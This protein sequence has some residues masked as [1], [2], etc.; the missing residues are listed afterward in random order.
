[1]VQVKLLYRNLLLTDGYD[2]YI[3]YLCTWQFSTFTNYTWYIHKC[4]IFFALHTALSILALTFDKCNLSMFSP[5]ICIHSLWVPQPIHNI[6][7]AKWIFYD[8]CVF[9]YITHT[10]DFI[11][12]FLVFFFFWYFFIFHFLLSCCLAITN[13]SLCVQLKMYLFFRWV[14]EGCGVA[15]SGEWGIV[16]HF[17]A[18]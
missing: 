16:L 9:I 13:F 12:F 5:L 18:Y 7:E 2:R 10:F 14:C 3:I 15:Y 11:H 8:M 6:V 17:S 4:S 1:M